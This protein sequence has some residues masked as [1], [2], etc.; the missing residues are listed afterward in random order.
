MDRFKV[1]F[2]YT[3]H[4][5]LVY[6]PDYSLLCKPEISF[7]IS[8][9]NLYKF[10]LLLNYCIILYKCVLILYFQ[11]ICL[12]YFYSFKKRALN[13]GHF[14][15]IHFFLIYAEFGKICIFCIMFILPFSHTQYNSSR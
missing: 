12:K 9:R 14:I 15:K 10:I 11:E 6:K 7:I 2:A 13:L 1:C 8:F 5:S 3:L 4:Y